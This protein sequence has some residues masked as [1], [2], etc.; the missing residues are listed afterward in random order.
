M[1]QFPNKSDCRHIGTLV[2]LYGYKGEFVLAKDEDI[3]IETED[4]ESVFIEID[5][6]LVP[7]FIDK[8]I[9]PSEVTAII[10]FDGI[11]L[12]DKARKFLNMEVFQVLSLV[13]NQEIIDTDKLN[14]YKVIDHKVKYIGIVDGILNYNQNLL[15]RIINEKK[16]ILIPLVEKII[17]NIN[18]KKQEI[19]INSP[20][21][22]FEIND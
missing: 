12:E 18:H 15:L 10:S 8:I 7:F 9:N 1:K 16:E 17:I 5:G 11:K 19:Y 3:V 13:S 20:D 14:G 6:L 22:L 2:K 21:G 4:W